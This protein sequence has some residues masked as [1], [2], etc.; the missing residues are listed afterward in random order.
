MVNKVKYLQEITLSD[1]TKK[2]A[3]S[4]PPYLKERLEVGFE[5]Y[6][7]R[8]DAVQRCLEMDE[9]H[10]RYLKNIASVVRVN[11]ATV[12]GMIGFY[13]T[14]DA[15]HRLSA[16]SKRTYNQL[17]NGLTKVSLS[18]KSGRFVDMMASNVRKDHVQKL[19]AHLR[20][21]AFD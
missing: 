10:Q 14:T 1:K 17:I 5:Q 12:L 4:P 2:W 18:T 9:L 11:S 7:N 13:K 19:F 3:F 16:N 6:D 8:A 21:N 20:D 15:W